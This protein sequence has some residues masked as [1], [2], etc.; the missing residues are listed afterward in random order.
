MKIIAVIYI[1]LIVSNEALVLSKIESTSKV[2]KKKLG[3]FRNRSKTKKFSYS[4]TKRA[5]TY[6]TARN[7]RNLTA[8]KVLTKTKFDGMKILSFGVMELKNYFFNNS[9]DIGNKI[10][11]F[12]TKQ[13]NHFEFTKR[14]LAK[15]FNKC[16]GFKRNELIMKYLTYSRI[17]NIIKNNLYEI[18]EFKELKCESRADEEEDIEFIC[19]GDST[20]RERYLIQKNMSCKFYDELKIILDNIMSM[21][22]IHFDRAKKKKK[23]HLQLP[24]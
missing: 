20:C 4:S 1:L 22:R 17:F 21:S 6:M 13:E 5:H 19:Q 2:T 18:S 7:K 14:R 24:Q 23:C 12:Q 15:I 3:S 9:S 8:F 11:D 10:Q 16:G